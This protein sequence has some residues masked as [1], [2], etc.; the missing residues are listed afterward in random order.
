MD[1]PPGRLGLGGVYLYENPCFGVLPQELIGGIEHFGS[2]AVPGPV[3]KPIVDML[4][5]VTDLAATRTRIA[6]NL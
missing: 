2:T 1:F 4:I 3:A 5:E 6:P